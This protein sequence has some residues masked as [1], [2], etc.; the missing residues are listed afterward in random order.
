M[1]E[2]MKRL[3]IYLIFALTNSAALQGQPLEVWPGDVTNNGVVNNIDFLH[4]G[5]AYNY[6]GPARNS[7]NVNWQPLQASPWNGQ[8]ANG[9]NYAYGD[10]NGDGIVNYFYDAFPIYVHYGKTHGPVAPDTYPAGLPGIDPALE[11]DPN[12]APAQV[13]GGQQFSLPILLGSPAIPMEDFYGVAF[14][15]LVDPEF[16]DADQ[17]DFD[18]SAASWANPDN[19]RIFSI[20]RVSDRRI[21]VGWV[22]T[23]HNE[24]SGYGPIGE[25]SFIVIDDVVSV[26][27]SFMIRIDSIKVYDRFGNEA[28]VA[29]DTLWINVTPDSQIN[30][31]HTIFPTRK[32]PRVSPNPASESIGI[33]ADA[34][35]RLLSLH[36]ASGRNLLQVRPDDR[37]YS[38]R[39]PE[40]RA[41]L[42]FLQIQTDT[43]LFF[44]KIAIQP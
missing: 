3:I 18:F 30:A 31:T 20:N 13:V 16:V 32:A 8:F 11:F 27:Q 40:L 15:V 17:V 41:G 10:C 7:I 19:D 6:V 25:A 37:R 12:A 39:L 22:R 44:Q 38:C 24:K 26:Q 29:G 14:S 23:D 33:E 43:G 34:P 21:D 5:L 2:N 42:Y 28:A 1:E 36:D 4:L 35:I 9:V